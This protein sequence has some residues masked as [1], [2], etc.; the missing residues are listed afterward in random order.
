MAG[1]WE[2]EANDRPAMARGL[3]KGAHLCDWAL[4]SWALATLQDACRASVCPSC[5]IQALGT[6]SVHTAALAGRLSE[7]QKNSLGNVIPSLEG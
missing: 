3:E 7:P 2:T 5:P 4:Q 1:L 6:R